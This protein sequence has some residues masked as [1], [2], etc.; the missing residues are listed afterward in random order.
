M[1]L[2]GL[3]GQKK[4]FGLLPV[5]LFGLLIVSSA[6]LIWTKTKKLTR[7]EIDFAI[8][9]YFLAAGFD[10][11]TA[12]NFV[13]QARHESDSYTS[14]LFLKSN[15]LFGMGVPTERQSLRSGE[16]E[17]AEGSRSKYS[18]VDD[19]IK[20]QILWADATNFPEFGLNPESFVDM[21]QRRGYFTDTYDNYLEGIKRYL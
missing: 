9:K 17:T 2:T 12:R 18:S 19:S 5:L 15:N 13:A 8:M 11:Q 6:F 10:T 7:E 16:I 4:R 21:L 3:S 20:D 1:L 14:P